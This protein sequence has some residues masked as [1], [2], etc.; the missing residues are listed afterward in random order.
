VLRQK[1]TI[2]SSAISNCGINDKPE[3][4]PIREFQE[5][6]MGLTRDRPQAIHGGKGES[7]ISHYLLVKEKGKTTISQQ[8]AGRNE[9]IYCYA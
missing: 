1:A 9:R 4:A 2:V 8:R 6:F 7:R 3:F 5:D